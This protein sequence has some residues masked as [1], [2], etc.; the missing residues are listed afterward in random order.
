MFIKVVVI[1][2]MLVIGNGCVTT[3]SYVEPYPVVRVEPVIYAQPEIVYTPV[4]PLYQ[5]EV[6]IINGRRGYRH[7][8]EYRHVQQQRRDEH[9]ID[10]SG[11]KDNHDS[12]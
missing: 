5:Y 7:R 6:V 9:S 4:Y 10:R 2:G 8:E 11:N 12:R 3:V 1:S